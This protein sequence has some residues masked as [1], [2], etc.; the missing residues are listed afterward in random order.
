MK[1]LNLLA[2]IIFSFSISAQNYT[3][4]GY[5]SDSESG[6]KLIAASVFDMNT[7][8]GTSTNAYG[9]YSITLP[10]DSVEL[11]FSYVG[12]KTVFKKLFLDQNISLN[13]E[14]EVENE[15]DEVVISAKVQEKIQEDSQMSEISI[16]MQKVKSLPMLL[17]ER[18]ILKTIQL[19]PGV[20]SGSEGGSGMYVRGARWCPGL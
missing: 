5:L 6:E 16:P 4:S 19:L 7:K 10:Q 12:Y 1:T 15:L 11:R 8:N 13:I 14:F 3:V 2:F 17:G 18:D 9:F 20:Q